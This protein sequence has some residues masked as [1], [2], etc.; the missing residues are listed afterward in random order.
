MITDLKELKQRP[1]YHLYPEEIRRQ[2]ESY[3][4]PEIPSFRILESSALYYPKATALV[5][6]PENL[7][8][9]YLDLCRL[10]EQFASGLQNKLKIDKGDRV[11]L[12]ARNYP[13]FLIA[14]FGIAMAGAVY[15]A[16]NPLLTAEEVAYQIK[17][18]GARA[19]ITSDDLLP[20]LLRIL[21][22]GCTSLEKIIGFVRDQ[23]LK[24]DFLKNELKQS[25]GRVVPFK[26][27]L[28]GD[29]LSK[30]DISPIT[31]LT[32]I[33]YTSGT[34]GYPKGVMIS[35]YN[36]VASTLMYQTAYT[37]KFPEM[38]GDG[39][40]RCNTDPQNLKSDW[41]YPIRFGLDSVL[42][43]PPWTHMLAYLGQCHFPVMAAMTIFPLPLFK[44]EVMVE[45]IR[46]WRIAFA[47]GAPQMMAMLLSLGEA[48]LDGLQ[49]IRAWT[50]GG[51]PVPE[52]LAERFSRVIDGVITEGYSLTEATISSTKHF[53]RRQ[54]PRKYGSIGIPL[55]FVDMKVVDVLTGTQETAPG[56]EGELIQKGPS[57]TLGYLNRPEDTKE[58]FRDGWLFTGDLA[59]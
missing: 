27:L 17:D 18:S 21:E 46:K 34:T 32:A 4:F 6:E 51:S 33:M 58:S 13:E 44:M 8:L 2:M 23:E 20:V 59:V 54:G 50:T 39:F 41:E 9:T 10:S 26:S 36:V 52:A 49:P 29:L 1:W 47:G 35:H 57:V 14:L 55:P 25:N 31:D 42:A 3:V 40:F 19:A 30:P 45:M 56:Q 16:C 15:V 12:Y 37:G 48:E 53:C 43:V 24:P 11:A 28:V 5:Y 22:G 7:I 38:D